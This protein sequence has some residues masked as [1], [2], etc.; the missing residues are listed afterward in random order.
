MLVNGLNRF[1]IH[2]S[3]HQPLDDKFPGF[4]L[5]PFGQWFTRHE[6]W[7]EMAGPWI[8]Y[9]SRCSYM[10]QQGNAIVDVAYFYGHDNNITALFSNRVPDVPKSYEYD[11]VN[12]NIVLNVL[13]VDK[14]G[15][16]VTPS[17]MSY[18]I[19]ALDRNCQKLTVPVL[20]KIRDLVNAGAIVVGEKT[21]RNT[22]PH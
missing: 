21:W 6:T 15:N 13:S 4:S 14:K 9:L 8:T 1:V 16:I 7:G 18:K 10:L 17:G 2:T 12:P 22:Y 11:F 5:G 3:V 20:R 19:L